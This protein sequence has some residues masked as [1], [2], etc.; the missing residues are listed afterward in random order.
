[1]AY[2]TLNYAEEMRLAQQGDLDAMFNIASYIVWED[3]TSPIEPEMAEIALD[4]YIKNADNGD[5]DSMLDLGAM[6]LEGRGV[7]KDKQKALEWY[8]KAANL[9]G[10]RA[11]R[12]IGNFYRYDVLDDGTPVP[13]E[14]PERL[15][16]AL[17]W[18]QTG[19]KRQEENCVYELGDYYRFGIIVEKDEKKAFELY[20]HALEIIIGVVLQ[21]EWAVNDSYADV[22]LRLAECYHYGIGTEPDLKKAKYYIQ[23]A[24]KE[25]KTRLDSGDKYGGSALS[26]AE[27]EWLEIFRDVG[28]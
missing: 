28:F 16:Q 2:Y 26:R 27:S 5:T 9:N 8:R 24:K 6:Y 10:Y 21:D 18:Y 22:C 13:T 23:I 12:C 17:E 20:Q 7:E 11:C 15:Q 3:P 4:Y 25:A 14:D 19:A 1:M